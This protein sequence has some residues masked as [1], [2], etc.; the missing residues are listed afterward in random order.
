MTF[1]APVAWSSDSASSARAS[2]TLAS[3]EEVYAVQ[4][5]TQLTGWRLNVRNW[6]AAVIQQ[7]NRSYRAEFVRA[8]NELKSSFPKNF[9]I[10]LAAQFVKPLA[11]WILKSAFKDAATTLGITLNDETLEFLSELAIDALVT[12]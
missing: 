11:V 8:A 5:Q 2:R 7:Q 9:W 6:L 3:S 12:A 4:Q 1:R 10:A